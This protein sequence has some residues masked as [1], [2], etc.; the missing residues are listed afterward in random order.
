[1]SHKEQAFFHESKLIKI[2]DEGNIDV[3]LDE[4][5]EG[6]PQLHYFEFLILLSKLCFIILFSFKNLPLLLINIKLLLFE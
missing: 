3:Y 1:M 6:E 4:H 2:Y 5:I